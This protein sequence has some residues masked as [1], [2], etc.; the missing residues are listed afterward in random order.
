M[1]F[2]SNRFLAGYYGY[3]VKK[4][5]IGRLIGYG[6]NVI[7]LTENNIQMVAEVFRS[8][9]QYKIANAKRDI[10]YANDSINQCNETLSMI[11]EWEKQNFK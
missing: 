10:A 6:D 8:K 7:V 3:Y 1:L 5:D 4:E 2:R 11:D 9:I